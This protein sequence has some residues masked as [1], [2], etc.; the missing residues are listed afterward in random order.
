MEA[1]GTVRCPNC[2]ERDTSVVDSRDLDDAAIRRR[3][4]CATCNSR[5]TT[6]ERIE[7]ARLTVVKRD[8]T[9][10]DFDR[11]KL[12]AGIEKAL[13]RRPVPAGAAD[14]AADAIEA[15]LRSQGVNEV[16]STTIGE[17]A[18][19]RLRALD[20]IAYI[21]FASVYQSL[22]RPGAAQARGRHA[23][24]GAVAR[25]ARPDVAGARGAGTQAARVHDVADGCHGPAAA[26]PAAGERPVRP[27]HPGR[28]RG[29]RRAHRPLR[30]GLPPAVVGR[31]PPGPRVPGVPQQ[32]LP[33]HRRAPGA[34]G[35]H[36]AGVHHR[37]GPVHPAS[38]RV[39]ARPDP[40]VG[41]AA[42][43]PR[44]EARGQVD[45]WAA[46]GCSSTRRRAMSTRAGRATSRSSC[47]TSRTC[48]SR[49]TS[50]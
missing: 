48:P 5:F 24:R 4:E 45:R 47:R 26:R 35:P 11:A 33:V 7:S 34:A 44:R 12:A 40:R 28:P 13:T 49:S 18:M 14:D 36:G 23:V 19:E 31:P 16:T 39:R 42:G 3:R 1:P 27:R 15:H 22:R 10:E 29:G 32:P 2:G 8:G 50:A 43:R 25:G 20:Q 46:W 37:R 30:P 38:R 21:R 41:R 17:M 9:R 6:Y